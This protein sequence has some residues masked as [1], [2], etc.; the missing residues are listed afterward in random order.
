MV[1][2]SLNINLPV[3]GAETNRQLKKRYKADFLLPV[4]CPPFSFLLPPRTGGKTM[5]PRAVWNSKPGLALKLQYG[6]N[7]YAN[8]GNKKAD[9]VEIIGFPPFL[10]LGDVQTLSLFSN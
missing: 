10:F 9:T 4:L 7:L 3:I 5:G 1:S 8:A 6:F 2:P